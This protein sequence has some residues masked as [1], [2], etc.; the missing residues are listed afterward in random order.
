MLIKKHFRS[1]NASLLATKFTVLAKRGSRR[2]IGL[3][4]AEGSEDCSSAK[5]IT[6]EMG[7]AASSNTCS[8][9]L[10]WNSILFLIITMFR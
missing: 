3:S 7:M 5:T 1:K 6:S 2:P 4:E 8:W 9:L 10:I